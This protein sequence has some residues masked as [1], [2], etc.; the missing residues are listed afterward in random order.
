M[1]TRVSVGNSQVIDSDTKARLDRVSLR[2]GYNVS[3]FIT[4]GSWSRAVAVSGST[5][6]GSGV[7]DV[8]RTMSQA[9]WEKL[10]RELA[11]ENV[12]AWIR[13]PRG[14]NNG[15]GEGSWPKHIHLVNGNVDGVAESAMGQY[16]HWR[17][18]TGDGLGGKAYGVGPGGKVGATMPGPI[19]MPPIGA[20][21]GG[22]IAA[23]L[24][25]DWI[26]PYL[27]AFKA[28]NAAL[29]WA[30][31]A[32][33]WINVLLIILGVILVLLAASRMSSVNVL[34]LVKEVSK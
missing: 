1:A 27:E 20:G 16:T 21:V 34:S 31:V 29:E 25:P 15:V 28:I 30:S 9:E 2:V 18:G 32:Q 7:A 12:A 4:Q 8:I 14:A 6:T 3:S 17:N 19:V 33:N 13:Y 24:V 22:D 5:H 10:Q 23:A 11:A 26:A